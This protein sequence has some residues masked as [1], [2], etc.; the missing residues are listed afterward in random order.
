MSS[1]R[2]LRDKCVFLKEKTQIDPKKQKKSKL[3]RF[4]VF[5]YNFCKIYDRL[6]S[7]I[8]MLKT[9]NKAKTLKTFFEEI[10]VVF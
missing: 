6:R 8:K 7:W 3:S 5:L 10:I 1:S 4:S 2:L 9:F